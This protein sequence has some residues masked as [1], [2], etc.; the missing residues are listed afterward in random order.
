MP[1]DQR[2]SDPGRQLKKGT[3]ASA[4][5]GSHDRASRR[6][7]RP[8]YRTCALDERRDRAAQQPHVFRVRF[9]KSEFVLAAF[10]DAERAQWITAIEA[11]A[12]WWSTTTFDATFQEIGLAAAEAEAQPTDGVHFEDDATQ[13]PD[14]GGSDREDDA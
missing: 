3:R 12:R 5:N 14:G 13:R 7:R 2:D 8:R 1:A 9:V 4:A 6:S 10:S 11:G